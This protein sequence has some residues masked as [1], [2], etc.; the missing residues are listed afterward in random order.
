MDYHRLQGPI[1]F[2][3]GVVITVTGTDWCRDFNVDG[4]YVRIAPIDPGGE[5]L[6]FLECMPVK[7][8]EA[9]MGSSSASHLVS[10]DTLALV[11]FGQRTA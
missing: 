4:Y 3:L 2:H 11:R 1:S 7:N 8:V 5:M 10:T 6:R 9:S